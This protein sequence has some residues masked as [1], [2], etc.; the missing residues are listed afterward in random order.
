MTEASLVQGGVSW[1]VE[2]ERDDLW[3]RE[4]EPERTDL[5]VPCRSVQEAYDFAD[6]MVRCGWRATVRGDDLSAAWRWLHD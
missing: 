6:R 2:L 4:P 5:S 1:S 3:E